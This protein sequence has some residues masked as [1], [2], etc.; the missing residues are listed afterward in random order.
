MVH[1][2]GTLWKHRGFLTST[3]KAIQNGHSFLDAILLPKSVAICK[4]PAHT[5]QPD[6]VSQ[7]NAAA[8]DT[9]AKAAASAPPNTTLSLHAQAA[10]PTQTLLAT[11]QDC[12]AA[13]STH[14]KA[15]WKR[16]GTCSNGVWLGPTGKPC[17]PRYRFPY[18]AKLTYGQDHVSKGGMVSLISRH[19]DTSG[20]STYAKKT[21]VKNVLFVL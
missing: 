10:T 11:V 7:G 5:G 19:W 3:G 15:S 13:A 2:F 20:F 8:A 17:L 1:D 16:D 4:C 6:A 14:E 12:Q 18:Y 9:A 21:F